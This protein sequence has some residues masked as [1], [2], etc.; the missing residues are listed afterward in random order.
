MSILL[1]PVQAILD[2]H[3]ASIERFGGSPGVRD[4]GGVEAALARAGQVMAYADV[5]DLFSVAAAVGFSLCKNRHPFVDGNKRAAWFAMFVIV[6]MNG[7]YLDAREADATA[8]VLG[9]AD[10]SVS[11]ERLIA[12]LRDNSVRKG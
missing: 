3:A 4:A 12:F 9:V 1:P 10:G 11:E 7:W 8:I 5:V 2:L 6:R